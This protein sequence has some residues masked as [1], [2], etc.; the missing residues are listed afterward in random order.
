MSND[1]AEKLYDELLKL[2]KGDLCDRCCA[3]KALGWLGNESLKIPFTERLEFVVNLVKKY[4]EKKACG[5]MNP[6]DCPN[7]E[8]GCLLI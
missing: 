5:E 2:E 3:M 1:I 8:Y 4:K 6:D 7:S